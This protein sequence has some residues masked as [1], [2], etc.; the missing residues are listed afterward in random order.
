MNAY[1]AIDTETTG[2]PKGR[3]DATPE[4]TALWNQCRVL[5][6]AVVKYSSRGRE[7]SHFYELIFPDTFQV[8]ATEI[9][10][11][12]E[13][14]AKTKG[15]PFEQA[16]TAFIEL[17]NKCPVVVGHNLKFDMNAILS[18]AFRRGLDVLPLLRVT[19]KCTLELAKQRFMRPMKLTVLYKEL[20]GKDMTGAHNA[21]CDTRACGEVYPMLVEDTRQ[22]KP[23][24]SKKIIIKASDVASVI[25][26][27]Q[28]KKPDEVRDELLKRFS[29]ETFQGKTRE[30]L[31]LHAIGQSAS[32]TH[33][34]QR[35]ETLAPGDVKNKLAAIYAAVD[36]DT[37]IVKE[38]VHDVKDHLRKVLYTNHGI[39]S[40]DITA[41]L[42]ENTLVK[43]DT[44]YSYDVCTIQGT[45][46]QI[47]GRIDRMQI[48]EDGSKM[49]VEIKNRSNGL[50]NKVRDYEHV[51]VQA[52]L[53]MTG[54]KFGRLIE[55]F[56]DVRKNYIIE[57]DD[58]LWENTVVPKLESFCKHFHTSVT[59]QMNI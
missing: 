5:S 43:D 42:D 15:V 10:G 13:E 20:T 59:P 33:L 39:R 26:M 4:N 8:A 9:H 22:Y 6:L 24:R 30:E 46:Y 41:D 11:I 58:E 12:T 23:I 51:Q 53:Q 34:L 37:T 54:I 38:N 32:A 7:Q 52:Y 31:A 28:F 50:F 35:T 44:F 57:R 29:P 27:N 47:V 19:R 3:Q 17:V 40:E 16:Y 14:D 49:V 55:H 1:L 36:Q 2:L 21:L 25:G 48:M 56:N 18:E 45:L